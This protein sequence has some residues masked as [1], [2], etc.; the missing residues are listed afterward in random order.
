MT[1]CAEPRIHL[2]I[3][4]RHRGG[5]EPCLEFGSAR[6]P[7]E[8]RDAL[9]GMDEFGIAGTYEARD[10]VSYELGHGTPA[11]GDDRCPTCERL[12]H[13]E[14]ERLG[15]VNRKQE[16][17]GTAKEIPF[18]RDVHLAQVL[19]ERIVQER[20]DGGL[21][22]AAIDRIDLCRDLERHPHGLG[23]GDG[24]VETLLGRDASDEEEV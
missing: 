20:A 18:S 3:A 13:D 4:K 22:V 5:R 24:R 10:A 11:P 19:D 15:P 12:D 16:C 21:E 8:R 7:V 1:S 17:A 6:A 14:S 9:E 2:E 23:E